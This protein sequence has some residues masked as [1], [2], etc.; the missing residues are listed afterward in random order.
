MSSSSGFGYNVGALYLDMYQKL[1]DHNAI[2]KDRLL[3]ELQSHN[4][5]LKDI[6]RLIQ[7]FT[8]RKSKGDANFNN[9]PEYIAL[10]DRIRENN[11]DPHTGQSILPPHQYR[12]NDERTIEIVLQGLS[13]HV[14]II[15]Q[16]V[17][18]STMLIQQN[19]QDMQSFSETT[20]KS[21]ELI[22]EEIRSVLRR[23]GN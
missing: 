14:K 5:N 16:E 7:A 19:Y 8:E 22:I 9:E 15:S 21:I 2:E 18:H 10:I 23:T 11:K 3:Q 17:N 4:S 13:D 12:W 1:E 6:S 20:R